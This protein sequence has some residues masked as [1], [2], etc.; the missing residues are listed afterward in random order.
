MR[1]SIST[2]LW[3]FIACPILF[4]QGPAGVLKS[5]KGE[6]SISRAG[7]PVE[8]KLGARLE[9]G[10]VI[11]TGSQASVGMAMLDGTRLALGEKSELKI[12]RFLYEPAESKLGL[13]LELIRG[14]FVYISGKIAKLSP[15]SVEIKAPAGVVGTRGTALA[16]RAEGTTP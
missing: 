12:E 3:L 7:M 5:V 13:S 14:I 4:G 1:S 6:V 15:Q 10:D 9:A 2:L 8:A 16:I 11:R